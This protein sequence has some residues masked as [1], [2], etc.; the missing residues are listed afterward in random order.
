MAEKAKPAAGSALS[1]L[2]TP[3]DLG[4][5]A[6]KDVS[7]ALNGLLADSYALY[8]K[9]KNFHWHGSGP[10]F[11]D[12]HLM[13]DD[14]AADILG[15]TDDIAERVR[16][17]GGQTLKSVNQIAAMTRVLPNEAAYVEPADM[18]AELCEDNQ[19]YVRELR[20][21][22]DVCDEAGDVASASLIENWLDATERRVWFLFE[23]LRPALT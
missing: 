13:L 12:Y 20:A 19:A 5:N 10:H 9:T 21:A 4:D 6:V 3:T 15:A 2:K 1:R 16:K 8:F 22:H 14:H 7:A 11:R 23:T 17:L 18:L